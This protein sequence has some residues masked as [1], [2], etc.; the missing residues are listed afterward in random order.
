[1]PNFSGNWKMKCS[2]NFEELLKAL[3]E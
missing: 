3:G 2:E 1:M